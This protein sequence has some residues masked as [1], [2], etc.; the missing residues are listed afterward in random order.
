MANTYT[1][2]LYHIVFSTK[3]RA[4]CIAKSRRDDLYAYIWG[5]HKELKCHLYRIG[6]VEDHV[7]ILTHIHP[8]IALSSY[9][10]KLKSGATNWI[11]RERIFEQWPG[12][13]DGFGAFTLSNKEKGTVVKYI[14][15]Q[16]EHHRTVA[17]ID[18]YKQLLT[19]AGIEYEEPRL[20]KE[21]RR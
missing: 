9:M 14:M 3:D 2:I 17:F 21:F 12:W 16:E 1:Q 15:G 20:L 11:R 7:H 18:E 19:E 5:I 13:Q 6:G 4:T 10:E 8:T